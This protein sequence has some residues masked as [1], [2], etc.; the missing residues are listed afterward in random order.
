MFLLPSVPPILLFI[1]V[2]ALYLSPL[3][4]LALM[5]AFLPYHSPSGILPLAFLELMPLL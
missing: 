4:L 2:S 5:S 1:E 3:G